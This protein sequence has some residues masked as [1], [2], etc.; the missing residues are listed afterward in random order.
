MT[1]PAAVPAPGTVYPRSHST[2]QGVPSF[3]LLEI[4]LRIRETLTHIA[5]EFFHFK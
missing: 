2:L 3:D 5:P 1:T 4:L